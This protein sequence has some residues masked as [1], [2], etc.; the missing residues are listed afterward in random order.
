MTYTAAYSNTRSLIHWV[1]PGIEPTFSQRQCWIFNPLSHNRNSNC[2]M[3]GISPWGIKYFHFFL[4]INWVT[5]GFESTQKSSEWSPSSPSSALGYLTLVLADPKILSHEHS[6]TSLLLLL[7]YAHS[8]PVILHRQGNNCWLP[9]ALNEAL[10]LPILCYLGQSSGFLYLLYKINVHF[11]YVNI[12]YH[13]IFCSSP[14]FQ[15]S[16]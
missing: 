3:F 16:V 12:L 7:H 15:F 6:H 4:L 5:V 1:R 11:C 10:A 9:M 2:W 13:W 14:A 8:I